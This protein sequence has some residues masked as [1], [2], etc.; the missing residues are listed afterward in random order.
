MAELLI[1]DNTY[2]KKPKDDPKDRIGLEIGDSKQPDKFYPQ[3]KIMRWDNEVNFSV[4]LVH[5][6]K[7]PKISEKDDKITW[8]GD[9]VEAHFY[10][11]QNEEHPEGASEFEVIL[12]EK[13]KINKVEFTLNTKGLDFF[14][15]RELT[16]KEKDKGARRPENVIGSYAVYASERKINYVGGKEYKSGKVGHIYRPKIVDSL[17][18]E[19]WGALHIENGILSVTI[20]QDFLDKAVYPIIVDPT[21]GYEV[22]GGSN[23]Y[24][25]SS[26]DSSE[27]RVGNYFTS[28]ADG[29]LDSISANLNSIYDFDAKV[30]V[31][32]KDSAGSGSHGQIATTTRTDIPLS[33]EGNVWITF[34]LSNE[35]IYTSIDY[36]LN[37]VGRNKGSDT[38]TF[39]SFD[40]VDWDGLHGQYIE[41][42]IYSAPEN[43]WDVTMDDPSAEYYAIGVTDWAVNIYYP[44][45]VGDNMEA[46]V[47]RNFTIY[48]SLQDHTSTSNDEPGVGASWDSC[49]AVAATITFRQFSIY[50]TYTAGG[51]L[52]IPVAMANYRRLRA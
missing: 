26:D 22:E 35:P 30:F 18:T 47:I 10:D 48:I 25:A 43:P 42:G 2:L 36:I 32:Q 13:P 3:V 44:A 16:Q 51:G 24:I 21:F 8:Q 28:P 40:D 15:Q 33:L 37:I 45:F 31:N 9:K 46:A 19:V 50:C 6:E 5:D 11:I 1:K 20:P 12:K 27:T 7:S 41:E 29:T 17:G 4:R 34:P 52:S 23:I 49:W 14:N 39:V 38:A